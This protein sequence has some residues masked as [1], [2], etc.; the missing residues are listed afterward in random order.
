MHLLPSI[1]ILNTDDYK[2]YLTFVLVSSDG[3]IF[4]I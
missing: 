3:I 2:E 4:E 1:G